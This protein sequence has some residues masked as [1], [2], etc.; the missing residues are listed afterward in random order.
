MEIAADTANPPRLEATGGLWSL[1][2]QGLLWTQFF[3]ALN[4]NIFRWLVIGI[5][6]EATDLPNMQAQERCASQIFTVS[7]A[8]T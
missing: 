5:G 3:T 6:K 1:G 7:S 8:Q 4:D 2:F